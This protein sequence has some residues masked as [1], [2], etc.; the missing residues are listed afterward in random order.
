MIGLSFAVDLVGNS[1]I[2]NKCTQAFKS[3]TSD[4]ELHSEILLEGNSYILGS[5]KRDQYPIEVF[6][7][8]DFN[9]VL[10][11]KIYNRKPIGQQLVSLAKDLFSDEKNASEVLA[12]WL[13][14]TDGEFIVFILNKPSNRI[15]IFN[16]ILAR[17]PAYYSSG[18]QFIVSRNYRFTSSFVEKKEIDRMAVAQN[19]LFGFFLENQTYRKNV[20][21]LEPASLLCVDIDAKS[22]DKEIVFQYN[23]DSKKH[24]NKSTK[25]NAK[26][27]AK[28]FSEA[29][30]RRTDENNQTIVSLSGGLD[31]RS[32]SSVL[33]ASNS[34]F[35]AVSWRDYQ[36]AA[37]LDVHVA[38]EVSKVLGID[39]ECVDLGPATG[40]DMLGILKKKNGMSR[41]QIAHLTTHFENL[42]KRYGPNITYFTGNGGDRLVHDLRPLKAVRTINGLADYVI[43]VRGLLPLDLVVEMTKVPRDEIVSAV[44]ETLLSYPEKSLKQ[45]LVHFLMYEEDIKRYFEGED[46]QR[47]FFWPGTPFYS[48]DF[49]NYIMNCPDNQKKRLYLYTSMLANLNLS[50]LGVGYAWNRTTGVDS[51]KKCSSIAFQLGQTINSWPNPVRFLFKQ[52]KKLLAVGKAEPQVEYYTYSEDLVKCINEQLKN[53]KVSRYFAIQDAEYLIEQCSK[54]HFDPLPSLFTAISA[55]EYL[56]CDKS[57]IENYMESN[58]DVYNV[59]QRVLN[60][61]FDK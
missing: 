13:P 56:L 9:I 2:K 3:S 24:A 14:K 52:I 38:E 31:S 6:D 32:I 42:K 28:L 23:F 22:V 33:K 17:L 39:W 18:D 46:R 53:T 10:E 59:G 25:E 40:K 12:S 41:L 35:R 1:E 54:C 51:I 4:A 44:K 15:I 5:T 20:F 48:P 11:G 58:L 21:R 49:Y 34:P 27:L 43:S 47:I 8:E 60:F 57:T 50:V 26:E 55:V 16:D 61:Q 29:V 45:K 37:G 36:N 7:S 30:I 19:L